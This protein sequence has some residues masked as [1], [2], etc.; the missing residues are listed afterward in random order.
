[1]QIMMSLVAGV[2]YASGLYLMM[3]RNILKLIIGLALLSHGANVL[4]F[5]MG[6]LDRAM[7]PIV[8]ARV[9]SSAVSIADPLPQALVL[10]AIVIGFGV[11]A[12]AVVLVLRAHQIIGTDDLDEMQTTDTL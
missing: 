6:G 11:Q 1:M 5:I 10:T 8:S 2:L 12:F 4:L 7:P 9:M 3:R